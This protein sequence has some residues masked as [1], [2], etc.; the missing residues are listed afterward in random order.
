VPTNRTETPQDK[1]WIAKARSVPI[2][3]ELERRGFL[4]TLRRKGKEL[5][6]ACPKK[7]GCDDDGFSVNPTKQVWHCRGCN[8]GGNVIDLVMWLDGSTFPEACTTLAGEKPK[9]ANGHSDDKVSK[10][11]V[12][13]FE[14]HDEEGKLLFVVDRVQYQNPDGTWVLKEGKPEK[15]FAQRRPDP[16][17]KG[18]WL[19]NVEGVRVVPYRLPELIEA[20]A[21][22]HVVYICEGEAKCDLLANWNLAATCNSQGA[23]KWRTEHAE[24]LRNASVILVPDNDGAG[25]EHIN[26]VGATLV[27]IAKSIRV[28]VLPDLPV[29]GDVIDWAKA[30]GNREK[31]DELTAQAHDW[32]HIQIGKVSDTNQQQ[33]DAAQSGE[34]ELIDALARMPKGIAYAREKQRLA[35][36]F[37]VNKADIETEA[38]RARDEFQKD[39]PLFGHWIVE[40]WP[41]PADG[42]AL[43]RDI[44]R[45]LRKHNVIS[46]EYALAC[47]LWTMFAWIHDEATFSPILCVTAAEMNSGKSTVLGVIAHL[48]PRCISSVDISKAALYRSIKR[49]NPS[50]AIDEFDN[51]LA[52]SGDSDKAELRAVI[53]SGHTR[54]SGVLRCITDEH[55]PEYFS[56]FCPKAIGM[57]GR[58]MPATTLSRCIFI[59]VQ[60]KKRTER[61]EEKFRR[62]DDSELQSLRSRLLKWSMDNASAVGNTNPSMPEGFDNRLADNWT[63]QFAI[64]DL[65]GLDWGDQAR[66]AAVKIEKGSDSRSVGERALAAIKT[67]REDSN[68]IGISSQSLIEILASDP[69]SEWAEW[70]NSK[71]ITQNALARLLKRFKIAPDKVTINGVQLRGYLW[72]WFEDAWERH[73]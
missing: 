20:I 46:Y 7:C 31:L 25:W 71:P 10:I 22:E 5:V 50:F 26:K 73:V 48:L 58:N 27:G 67:I 32:K 17:R 39:A 72:A 53:N 8:K 42:D 28:L 40:P 47:A 13:S 69:G 45:K 12:A 9:K 59:E 16:N 66:A 2:E 52:A 41:E 65:A 43:L 62:R 23:G 30:G 57:I 29:K 6:G 11:V 18:K 3:R 1:E 19:Y 70:R 61:I 56:T 33:K 35:D 64:A 34:K 63:L 44:I 15:K 55:T 37:G 14:Y 21:N 60:R 51:A 54:D 24:F 4:Q 38:R 49:W 36:A 68:A